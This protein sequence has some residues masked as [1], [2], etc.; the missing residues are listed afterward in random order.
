[1]KN[2]GKQ[3]E[4]L[5]KKR[6]KNIHE[7]DTFRELVSN[8]NK[9]IEEKIDTIANRDTVN[10]QG[11]SF[12]QS[13]LTVSGEMT[14]SYVSNSQ[15]SDNN[16]AKQEIITSEPTIKPSI[17]T[18]I[19]LSDTN[20]AKQQGYLQEELKSQ[21]SSKSLIKKTKNMRRY[22]EVD[23]RVSITCDQWVVSIARLPETKNPQHAFLILE[24]IEDAK[25][26]TWFIDFVR[27]S[28]GEKLYGLQGL[29]KVRIDPHEGELEESLVFK[30]ELKA[31]SVRSSSKLIYSSWSIDVEKANTLLTKVRRDFE[32]NGAPKDQRIKFHLMGKENITVRWSSSED[33]HSCFTWARDKLVNSGDNRIVESF[34][35]EKDLIDSW[36]AP[37]TG[38]FLRHPPKN[39][40]NRYS[41]WCQSAVAVG[42]TAAIVGTVLLKQEEIEEGVRTVCHI[43]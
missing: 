10:L 38:R 39:N 22:S 34:N 26:K 27:D 28:K 4:I 21:T 11:A 18:P 25:A 40:Q 8:F 42:L 36:I 12:N 7:S 24:G 41:M 43:Q 19:E 29:G 5:G 15:H 33:G 2:F 35:L 13:P 30:C 14:I 9:P 1:M 37:I 31:M 20:S 16:N 32:K 6:L 17:P 3:L 23:N